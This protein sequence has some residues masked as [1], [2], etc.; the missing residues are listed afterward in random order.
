MLEHVT[1][2]IPNLG[3]VEGQVSLGQGGFHGDLALGCRGGGLC[4]DRL[5]F[6]VLHGVAVGEDHGEGHKEVQAHHQNVGQEGADVHVG[7]GGQQGGDE[8][9][10]TRQEPQSLSDRTV[11]LQGLHIGAGSPGSED[12]GGQQ[13][14]QVGKHMGSP[15]TSIGGGEYTDGRRQGKPGRGQ[16]QEHIPPV[17]EEDHGEEHIGGEGHQVAEGGQEGESKGQPP[18]QGGQFGEGGQAKDDGRN[19]G[20]RRNGTLVHGVRSFLFCIVLS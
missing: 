3:H 4:L 15:K 1:A 18:G 12:Q 9:Q 13:E 17:Q 7:Q 11:L 8:G 5:G 20:D 2:A 16:V 19:E 14:A 10:D 6:Q